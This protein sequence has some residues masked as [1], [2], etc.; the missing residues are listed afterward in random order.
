MEDNYMK[1][2]SLFCLALSLCSCSKKEDAPPPYTPH[3]AG[4]WQGTG[5]DNS[6]G[7]YNVS[8]TLTQA[9]TAASGTFQTSSTAFTTQ[10]DIRM[11]IGPVGG[12]NLSYVSLVRTSYVHSCAGSMTLSQPTFITDNAVSL[13]YTLVDCNGTSTGGMSLKKIAGTN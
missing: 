1:Y 5:T 2:I 10:G 12:N 3:V 6:I 11:L 9:G 8:M 13:Y 7:F 4:Q